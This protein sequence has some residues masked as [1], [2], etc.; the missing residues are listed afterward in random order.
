[1]CSISYEDDIDLN[2]EGY[3]IIFDLEMQFGK[4]YC[5]I[6]IPACNRLYKRSFS[7]LSARASFTSVSMMWCGGKRLCI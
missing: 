1:M 6:Q 3:V 2:S 5:I 7:G 4:E